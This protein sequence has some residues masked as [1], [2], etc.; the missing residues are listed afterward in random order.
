MILSSR[1]SGVFEVIGAFLWREGLEQLA[2]CRA[3]GFN[4]AR[5]AFSQQVF[6]LGK[7]LFDGVQVRRVF[8]QEEQLIT[9]RA[10][11]LAHGFAFVA[12]EIV[13]D[14]DVTGLQGGDEDLLDL[15]PE[16]V[17][18]DGTVE[19]PWSLDP[20]V[21]QGGQESR[22]HRPA[23]RG[24]GV[25]SQDASRPTQWITVLMPTPNWAAAPRRDIPPLSTAAT[26]RSRRSS[27]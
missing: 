25:E 21:A 9:G 6:E 4:G 24:L 23:V 5:G 16:A 10:N 2:D 11:E 26:T 14:D 13:D 27:E 17:P 3:E 18:V 7:D 12:A 8:W 20:V 22:G 1:I 15:G 19:H